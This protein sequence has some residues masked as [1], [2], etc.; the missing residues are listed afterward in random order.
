MRQIKFLNMYGDI[1]I[2][3]EKDDDK[4]MEEIL[5]EK[6]KEG[7]QFFII[8]K[9]LFGLY[10]KMKKVENTKEVKDKIIIKDKDMSVFFN[11]I[12]SLK[13]IQHETKNETYNVTKIASSA[14]E[15]INNVT[16]CTK[17]PV[18]G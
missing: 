6:L 14:K 16:I 7:Y 10:N 1:V 15:I 8:E 4:M 13:T 12:N 5:N 3:W 11:K 17:R 18:A 9:K 2:N